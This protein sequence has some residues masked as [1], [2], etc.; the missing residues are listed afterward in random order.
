MVTKAEVLEALGIET[1]ENRFLTGLLAGAGVGM[2]VGAAVALLLAP[3]SGQELR[4]SLG[5]R[6]REMSERL[7]ARY[8]EARRDVSTTTPAEPNA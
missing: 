8:E 2:L 6:S 7:R 4:Q 5:D 3:R 1:K